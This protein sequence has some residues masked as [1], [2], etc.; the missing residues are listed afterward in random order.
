[1]KSVGRG[2]R[3]GVRTEMARHGKSVANKVVTIVEWLVAIGLV[4][5]IIA[6]AFAVGTGAL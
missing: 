4:A 3:T 6:G 2:L 1:M 5:L